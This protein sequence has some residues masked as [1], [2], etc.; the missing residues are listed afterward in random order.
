MALGSGQRENQMVVKRFQGL[1][2]VGEW[3]LRMGSHRSDLKF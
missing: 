2:G 1:V 3:G